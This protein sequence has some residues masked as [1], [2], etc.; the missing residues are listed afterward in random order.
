M[1]TELCNT[2]IKILSLDDIGYTGDIEEDGESFEENAV[3]KATFTAYGGIDTDLDRVPV[4]IYYP[5]ESTV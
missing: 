5:K 4:R 1:L 3:I 2:E